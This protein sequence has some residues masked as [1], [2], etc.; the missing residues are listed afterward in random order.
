MPK[1]SFLFD[2]ALYNR[3]MIRK[4]HNEDLNAIQALCALD[5]SRLL[6]IDGDI[7]QNGLHTAY[8]ETWIDIENNQIKSIFLRYHANMVIYFKEALTDVEGF[9]SLFDE[10]IKMISAYK[11]DIDQMPR[12]VKDRFTFKEMYFC[13]CEKLIPQTLNVLPSAVTADESAQI[14]EAIGQIVEFQASQVHES[15]AERINSM[16]ERY[17]LNKIHGFIIKE[18][19]K[20]VAHAATGVETHSAVMVVGVFTLPNHRHKGY[21]RAVVSA[22]TE[23]ALTHGQKPCLFYDNPKAGKIYLDLGYVHFDAWCLGSL[24]P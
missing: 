12:S 21:G 4:A 17:Q 15:K 7:A 9:E 8:Q 18:E 1:A 19:D 13:E 11:K 20:I 6:F 3:S 23:Y 24:K 2:K 16:S 5:S 22:L 10:R 14:V